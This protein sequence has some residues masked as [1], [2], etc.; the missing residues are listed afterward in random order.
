MKKYLLPENGTFY[1]ANLHCHTNFSDAMLSPA[2][3]KEKYMAHGYSVVAFT[4]HDILIAHPELADENFLPL[5][6]FEAEVKTPKVEGEYIRKTCHFCFIATDPDNLTMPFYHRTKDLFGNALNYRDQ[7][8]IDETQPDFVRAYTPERINEMVRMGREKGFFVIYAHPTWSLENY[9]DYMN[10][11][12]MHAMEICNYSSLC[13]GFNE[14]NERE[15]DD[16]LRGGK[17]IFCV[18]TD[19]NHNKYPEN[20]KRWDSFGGF[21]MIKADELKYETI[22]KA[23]L[24]GNFY[25]S[26]GPKIH[27]LWVEDGQLHITCSGAQRIVMTVGKRRSAVVYSQDGELLEEASFPLTPEDIYVRVTVTDPR[28]YHAYTNAYFTDELLD[29]E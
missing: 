1:K 11:E 28:G 5:N 23:L 12:G 15:Y 13:A 21:I 14:Q 9:A 7:L 26:E 24:D 20:S 22:T 8:K 27:A 6:G 4:D 17:R 25:A 2:E 3:V 29:A 18:A 19:D 16:M 10:Y